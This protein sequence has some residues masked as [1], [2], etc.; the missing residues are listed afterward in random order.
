M[1]GRG[2]PGQAR[3]EG[4]EWFL[5]EAKRGRQGSERDDLGRNL[6]V[7]YGERFVGDE[8]WGRGMRQGGR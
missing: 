3:P 4:R 6:W 8:A 7:C 2:G 1:S 5:G